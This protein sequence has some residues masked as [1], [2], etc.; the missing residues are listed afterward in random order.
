MAQ[1]MGLTIT[2]CP[3]PSVSLAGGPQTIPIIGQA[4][5]KLQL[6]KF[7]TKLRILILST[8]S[9]TFDLI[10]GDQ[11]LRQHKAR[12][13]MSAQTLTLCHR[14][15][16][17]FTISSVSKT[18]SGS[19]PAVM[20]HALAHFLASFPSSDTPQMITAKG[21]RKLIRQ[22]CSSFPFLVQ[23]QPPI[24]AEP[25]PDRT[26]DH[27]PQSG[28]IPCDKPSQ[29]AHVS[30]NNLTIE[31]KPPEHTDAAALRTLTDSYTDIFTEVPGLPPLRDQIDELIPLQPNIPKIPYRNCYRMSPKEMSAI[32]TTVADFLSKRWIRPSSSLFGSPVLFIPK[33]DGS[34]RL[35]IDYRP[36]NALT[37]RNRYPIPRIEDL[38]DKLQGATCFSSIDLQH[39]FHQMRILPSDIPKTAF[40]T[41]IGHFEYVVLP[42]G[43]CNGPSGFQSLMN[44]LFRDHLDDFVVIYLDDILVFSKN[45][46]DHLK[47]LRLVFDILRKEKLYCRLH[48]CDFLQSEMKFLGHIVGHG[49]LKMDPSKTDTITSW[50]QPNTVADLRSF[51]GLSNYFRKYI[52]G[53][54]SLMAPLTTL[55]TASSNRFKWTDAHSAS[56]EATKTALTSAP[57]LALPNP[58]KPFTL[59]CDASV[60]GMGAVLL[61]ENHPVSYYS[62]KFSSTE[63]NYTTGEQELYACHQA[64]R[65]YRCYLKGTTFDLITDHCPLIYLKTQQFLSPKQGRW[66]EFFSR[67]EYTWKHIAGRNNVADPL[68][69]HPAFFNAIVAQGQTLPDPP[70]VKQE[71]LLGYT[72]DT[73]FATKSFTDKLTKNT[74]GFWLTKSSSQHPDRITIPNVT[75]LKNRIISEHHDN[76]L[77]GHQGRDRTLDLVSRQFYW[78]GLKKDVD[79]YIRHCPNCHRNKSHPAKTQGQ[80]Q[81]LPIPTEPWEQVSTDF[82]TGILK[83]VR[84]FDAILVFVCRLTKMVHIIPSTKTCTAPRFAQHLF[85]HVVQYH[86][87]P[88]TLISDRGKQFSGLFTRAF[89]ELMGTRTTLTSAYHPQT[90]GQTERLNRVIE[91]ILRHFVSNTPD[92]WDL[93]LPAVAFAINNAKQTS[94]GFSPFY[95]NY[96][97]HPHTPFSREVAEYYKL[98]DIVV[99]AATTQADKI[100]TAISLAKISIATAQ[101]RQKQ[102]YDKNKAPTTFKQG[103]YVY[104]NAT[105]LRR[106]AGKKLLPKHLGPYPITRMVG[107]N[108]AELALTDDLKRLHNVFNVSLLRLCPPKLPP[109]PPLPT[110]SDTVPSPPSSPDPEPAQG[111]GVPSFNHLPA[112]CYPTPPPVVLDA[113]DIPDCRI[114]EILDHRTSERRTGTN[115]VKFKRYLK[116]SW[117]GFP[118]Y[119]DAWIPESKFD[120]PDEKQLLLDYFSRLTTGS[121]PE[122]VVV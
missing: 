34:L 3:L 77:S 2:S 94:T 43:I 45:P 115:L 86:G 83:T 102:Y 20:Q 36:V 120:S 69:R 96:G 19:G 38:F 76:R 71:I 101:N 50:P 121:N 46:A 84:G 53:Y 52:Q 24:S 48:K 21:A 28:T 1:R 47:H 105:N 119:H 63:K 8:P 42:M 81:P 55:L 64:L 35:C 16:S 65:E 104:L 23:P 7:T 90:N 59:I 110:P 106:G 79:D 113:D 4:I 97:R 89:A 26:S 103:D 88:K 27:R 32:K 116:V 67:F 40:N 87:T 108:A 117:K 62:R 14:T 100:R 31:P 70:S 5:A 107:P 118:S 109:P 10:L 74:D 75:V 98:S 73:S 25:Q 12:I 18:R 66:M 122:D 15:G 92:D 44:R 22:G 13:D 9:T 95:L 33:P 49:H 37:I 57:L 93:L 60:N 85:E 91:E 6:G 80:L 58:E 78:S 61:Q 114:S 51:L 111:W 17:D 54:S 68:S 11:F 82:L 99:P 29:T 112:T 41:P 39:G 56:F 72:T 30:L